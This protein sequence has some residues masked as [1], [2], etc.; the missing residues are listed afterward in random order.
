MSPRT[1]W[2]SGG[3]GERPAPSGGQRREQPADHTGLLGLGLARDD[4][5]DAPRSED[6]SVEQRVRR[7]PV[8]AVHAGA[9][10]LAAGPQPR[11]R[12]RAVEVGAHATGEVVGRRRDREPVG[13]WD[14]ARRPDTRARPSGTARRSRRSAWRR[15]R[16]GRARWSMHR[17]AIARATTSRGARSPS[18]WTPCHERRPVLVAQDR[19]LAA[20]R[21]GEERPR[22]RRD[23][24]SAVGWNCMNSTSATATPARSAIAIPS[25]VERDGL[26]VTAKHWPA[27]PVAMI[28]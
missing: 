10:R 2:A 3:S 11:E 16:G 28:V 19:A 23:G 14:R 24:A 5:V 8:R 21:L 9:R 6:E 22:H 17:R 18:G 26:V 1:H 25:P 27:P 12:R 7:E 4:R 15:A 20:Q 13:A